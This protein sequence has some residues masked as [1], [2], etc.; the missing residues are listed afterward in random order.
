MIDGRHDRARKPG[1]CRPTA[2]GPSAGAR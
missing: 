1:S 2:G